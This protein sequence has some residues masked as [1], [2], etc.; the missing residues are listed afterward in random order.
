MM[1]RIFTDSD[2]E[3]KRKAF[4]NAILGRLWVLKE[5]M[6]SR[7]I[8]LFELQRLCYGS[9]DWKDF[10]KIDRNSKRSGSSCGKG[11]SLDCDTLATAGDI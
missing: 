10:W 1:R 5:I 11:Y 7:Q 4:Y 8:P 2:S 9:D 6:L 3:I